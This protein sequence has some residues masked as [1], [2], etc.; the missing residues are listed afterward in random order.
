M[1][2]AKTLQQELN[3]FLLSKKSRSRAV[4][5]SYIFKDLALEERSIHS[6][7]A[8]IYENTT[9]DGDEVYENT[10]ASGECFLVIK[11]ARCVLQENRIFSRI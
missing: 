1:K 4:G 8:K 11:K 6:N 9:A 2:Y 10:T 7:S 3:V 5:N